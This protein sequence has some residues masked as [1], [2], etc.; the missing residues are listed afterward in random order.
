MPKPW[1]VANTVLN[2]T[3]TNTAYQVGGWVESLAANYLFKHGLKRID[4]NYRCRLG[5]V[6]LIM[7]DQQ[8]LVFVEVRY[9]KNNDF[10][11]A[12]ASVT[13]EKQQKIRKV[14]QFYLK[15]FGVRGQYI[16]C[17]FD[18]IAVCSVSEGLQ[19]EWI[20]DAF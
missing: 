8:Y 18:V 15:R 6:D 12:K 19:V 1:I 5:E 16:F 4:Q 17:R 10:G 14:A 2:V 7:Q 3:K 20:K 11:G 9:R 13:R